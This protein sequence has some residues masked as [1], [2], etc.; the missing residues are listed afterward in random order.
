MSDL[1]LLQLAEELV[2]FG[3]KNGAS[4]VEVSIQQGTNFSVDVREGEIEKLME[5][6][7]KNLGLRLFVDGKMARASSSDLS[8][9]TLNK[10]M[11]NAILRAKLSSADPFAGLPEKEPVTIDV[12]SL[13]IY[14]P[15]VL[16]M[17][18]EKKIA[19]AKEVEA[20][21]LKDRRIAKSYGSTFN[22]YMGERFLANSNGF[23][24]A[25]KRTNCSNGVYL[26]AGE[27]PNLFD[28]G[29]SDTSVHLEKLELPE[30]IAKKAIHRVTRLIGGKKIE[31]QNVP[32]VFEPPMTAG[33]LNFFATCVSG[34]NIYLKQS[35]LAGKIGEKV[36]NDLVNIIDDGLMPGALGTE[37]FDG[38]GV[39][40]R[41]TTLIEKGTLKNYLLDTYS[42]KK[43]GMKTTGNSGGPNNLYLAAGSFTPEQIIKSVDKGLFLTGTIGFGQVPTT[44]D[45]SRG[46]FGIWIE[47]GELTYPV[48]EITISGNLAQ[49][50]QG[51]QM[52]GNDL[53]FKDSITGPTIKVAEMTVGGK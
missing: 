7:S 28:E 4:Q 33:L 37:L 22:T 26:Q 51:I 41:K 31:S 15:A 32:V 9:D 16:E 42:A 17:A 48:A 2:E 47:K 21:C 30:T 35:F 24:G 13:K 1:N 40:L 29:W 50:L 5:A 14:D 6:V 19:A 20:I 52:V 46:A 39:P 18:P 23:S 3:R 27:D 12:A 36:G 49:L 11:L 34:N 53:Q 38:E 25:F 10:L 45:I 43:L 44:G 8:K